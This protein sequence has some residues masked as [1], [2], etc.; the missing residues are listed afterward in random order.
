MKQYV[1]LTCHTNYISSLV[2]LELRNEI[3]VIIRR[4]VEVSD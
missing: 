3:L 1:G 2:L 4:G